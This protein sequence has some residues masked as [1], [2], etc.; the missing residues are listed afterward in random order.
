MQMQD[1][2]NGYRMVKKSLASTRLPNLE[3]VARMLT[4]PTDDAW[5]EMINF[6]TKAQ[7][8]SA[9][10]PFTWECSDCN[11]DSHWRWFRELHW[12]APYIRRLGYSIRVHMDGKNCCTIYPP[13]SQKPPLKVELD[14]VKAFK[15]CPPR[16]KPKNKSCWTD[17]EMQAMD[18]W[19]K[20]PARTYSIMLHGTAPA[21]IRRRGLLKCVP[22]LLGWL[23]AARIALADPRRPGA[24]EGLAEERAEALAETA[25]P[26]WANKEGEELQRKRKRELV[27]ALHADARDVAKGA[28]WSH[29][30]EHSERANQIS[31]FGKPW[32]KMMRVE[33]LAG[34]HFVFQVEG[35][36]RYKRAAYEVKV[37]HGDAFNVADEPCAR[38]REG[39][40]KE[41]ANRWMG[42][43]YDPDASGQE[44]ESSSDS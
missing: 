32:H 23:R 25:P 35:D 17:E 41:F 21:Q 37:L 27:G 10:H 40:E 3:D 14:E 30:Q 44:S 28:R 1:A 7:D 38:L 2:P 16:P 39:F 15:S 43:V 6:L 18:A 26:H 5:S 34:D 33:A 8:H 20:L 13:K 22:R 31:I 19:M 4:D 11:G 29:I 12:C 42:N 9:M 24:L 36:V